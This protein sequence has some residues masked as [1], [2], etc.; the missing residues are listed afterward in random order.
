MNFQDCRDLNWE[1]LGV[2]HTSALITVHIQCRRLDF[3]IWF[4]NYAEIEREQE[5]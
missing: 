2:E 4:D 3:E 1:V 5:R